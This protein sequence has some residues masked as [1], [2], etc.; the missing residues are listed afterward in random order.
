MLSIK[1]FKY[2]YILFK[3]VYEQLHCNIIIVMLLLYN[4][5]TSLTAEIGP[6]LLDLLRR[7]LADQAC[8]AA[9]EP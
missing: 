3:E 7:E 6:I 2:F 5:F 1:Q 8:P 4:H 9:T